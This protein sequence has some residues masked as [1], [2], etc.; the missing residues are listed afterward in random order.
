MVM[1]CW[2]LPFPPRICHQSAFG[3]NLS[4]GRRNSPPSDG[5]GRTR[6]VILVFRAGVEGGRQAGFFILPIFPIVE[7]KAILP[8]GR[9]SSAG[10]PEQGWGGIIPWELHFLGV[11]HFPSDPHL[12][13]VRPIPRSH[14][15]VPKE[16]SAFLEWQRLFR[17]PREGTGKP[18]WERG[19][20]PCRLC[21][22]Q[23]PGNLV[24][25]LN[26]GH[27]Q[28]RGSAVISVHIP[29]PK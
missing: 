15:R 6:T 29:A 4:R 20:F 1:E 2:V 9:G 27:G 18:R 14:L 5:L 23:C 10:S 16:T 12:A 26:P 3:S 19:T 22:V 8:S 21:P 25:P 11:I 28:P 13:Q 17:S 24:W 7:Q